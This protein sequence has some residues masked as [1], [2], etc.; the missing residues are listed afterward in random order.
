[1]VLP[2]TITGWVGD[3]ITSAATLTSISPPLIFRFRG[4]TFLAVVNNSSCI[5]IV[6]DTVEKNTFSFLIFYRKQN[7]SVKVTDA[8]PVKVTRLRLVSYFF[9]LYTL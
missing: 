2:K 7:V 3:C 4:S 5:N 6:F 1:M 9:V 8:G